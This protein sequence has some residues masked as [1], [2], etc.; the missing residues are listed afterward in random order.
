MT[1]VNHNKA[2][3]EAALMREQVKELVGMREEVA[4]LRRRLELRKDER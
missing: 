4:D 1:E 2:L 3:E